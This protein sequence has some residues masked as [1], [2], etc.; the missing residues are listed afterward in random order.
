MRL[1][2]GLLLRSL[3]ALLLMAA[4]EVRAGNARIAVTGGVSNV[5]GAAGGGLVP[6]A[7]L[8]G[9]ASQGEMGGSAFATRARVDDLGLD[10]HGL[11]LTFED[12]VE[13]SAARQKLHIDPLDTDIEQ[14]VFGVKL[15]LAGRLPYTALPQM[16]LGV[17][18]K[19]NRDFAGIPESLGARRGT[20][21]EVYLAAS[22]LFFAAM[23]G[24]NVFTNVTLRHSRAHEIGLMGFGGSRDLLI[25]SSVGVFLTDRLVLGA[26]YRQ[27]K[28]GLP[29]FPESDWADLFI[30]WFPS[31]HLSVTLAR[32]DLGDVV[33]F[34]NET[35]WYL[36]L[37]GSF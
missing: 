13:F 21:V 28:G 27:K 15:R 29:G 33:L 31:R 5:E 36:S 17:Q 24:R 14:D 19:R 20:D 9:Y 12:R 8:A 32:L 7:L 35:G 18:Y 37:E 25:E 10:V 34:E 22:K 11:A 23:A 26:E 16:A 2:S 1:G 30:A 3:L 6:W 4:A